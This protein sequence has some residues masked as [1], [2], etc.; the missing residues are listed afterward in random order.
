MNFATRIDRVKAKV[1]VLKQDIAEKKER[2]EQ[3]QDEK[4]SAL[5]A[6]VILQLAAKNTQKNIEVHFS[7]L[8]TK[9]LSIVFDEPYTFVPEFVERRNKTEC[10]FW[11]MKNGEK[12]RPRFSVGGGVRDVASFAL[13]LSYWK[14]EN[15]SPVLILD[16][17][18]RNLS[19][20]L[21]PKA[22]ETLKYLSN[23]F[24]LQ[25][26]IVTHSD[27][28]MKQADKIFEVNKGVVHG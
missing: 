6:K 28:I 23:M 15:S 3:C 13:R 10:D 24:K 14:L 19:R 5:E 2:L 27:E 16:E 7:D 25:M 18:F 8:V 4:E 1:S 21:V 26:I 11:F 20:T 12:L 22:A 9:A 17:P